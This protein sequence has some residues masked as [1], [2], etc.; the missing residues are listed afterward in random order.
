[1]NMKWLRKRSNEA[2]CYSL[3]EAAEFLEF[4]R[5]AVEYWL[6]MGHLNG[7]WDQRERRWRIRPADLIEFLQ[8]SNEPLPTGWSWRSAH[9]D[10]EAMDHANPA[11]PTTVPAIDELT[12]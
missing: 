9:V 12:Q 10:P 4:D 6:R 3:D 7:N 1:M 11:P 8:Q 2:R 5:R